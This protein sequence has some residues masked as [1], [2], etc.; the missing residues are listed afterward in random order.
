MNICMYIYKGYEKIKRGE[1]ERKLKEE[2]LV[3]IICQYARNI[4]L[5]T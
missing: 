4:K 5:N 3:I 2:K 1:V